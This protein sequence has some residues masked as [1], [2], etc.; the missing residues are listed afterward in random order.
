MTI[1][2]RL[3]HQIRHAHDII[4]TG[5]DQTSDLL[6]LSNI[7]NGAVAWQFSTSRRRYLQNIFLLEESIVS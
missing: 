6:L 1:S 2:A 5:F 7:Q 3:L 4:Y